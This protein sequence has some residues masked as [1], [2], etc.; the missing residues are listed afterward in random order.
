[1]RVN[2]SSNARPYLGPVRAGLAVLSLI[3]VG[4]IGWD[5]LHIK[6]IE[7]QVAEAG[8]ALAR[9]LEQDNRLRL[10][11]QAEGM[12]LSEAAVQRLP[13]EVAFANHVIAK[14]IFSWTRLL[15]DLEEA[16]P[17]R[18]AINTIQLDPKNSMIALGGA[19]KSLQDL[20]AF[21]I[22]LE[23]HHAFKD[24]ALAQHRVTEN[25]LVEFGLT[26]RYN[27]ESKGG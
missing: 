5:L 15:T 20:T 25:G 14:R 19:A 7:A 1:M 13:A 24:V 8:Q 12:D 3:F 16:V 21:I 22:R 2:L 6:T 11:A 18:V 27:R 10:Q 23:E 4:L 9:V 17:P 26:V